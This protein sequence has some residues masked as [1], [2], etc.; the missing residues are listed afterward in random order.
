[1]SPTPAY[2]YFKI[3]VPKLDE[4]MGNVCEVEIIECGK[5]FMKGK[6]VGD[7][8]ITK[9]EKPIMIRSMA[10]GCCGSTSGCCGS[11]NEV[12]NETNAFKWQNYAYYGLYGL[13]L[14]FVLK[15]SW[16]FLT[17]K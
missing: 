5:Y 12:I 13:S 3:L 15:K 14:A 2:F 1:M 10:E 6:L 7:Q 8:A 16:E 4:L 17:R 11:S 9:I